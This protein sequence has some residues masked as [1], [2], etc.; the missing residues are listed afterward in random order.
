MSSIMA[1]LPLPFANPRMN[2]GIFFASVFP[3]EDL[4]DS[5]LSFQKNNT[6][7]K[8]TILGGFLSDTEGISNNMKRT[9]IAKIQT[10]ENENH[11]GSIRRCHKNY[12]F[13]RAVFN[14]FFQ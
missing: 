9:D 1:Y 14:L 7:E 10:C 13:R 8:Y 2:K 3:P 12:Y 6:H 11:T 5:S 4:K